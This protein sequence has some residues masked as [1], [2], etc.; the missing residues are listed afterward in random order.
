[1]DLVLSKAKAG[2]AT[3]Q[4]WQPLLNIGCVQQVGW[5]CRN[6]VAPGAWHCAPFSPCTEAGGHRDG[7]QPLQ[8]GIPMQVLW[9]KHG[10]NN[11]PK[12]AVDPNLQ[13]PPMPIES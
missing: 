12:P 5:I 11:L 6:Q 8:Q 9:I 7:Q 4:F 2:G 10:E 3:R 13:V 1:M